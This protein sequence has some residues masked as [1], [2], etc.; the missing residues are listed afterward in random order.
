MSFIDILPDAEETQ[1]VDSVV[2]VTTGEF[3]LERLQERHGASLTP[4]QWTL[5]AE[6]GWFGLTLDEAQGGL[7]LGV[8][9][10]ALLHREFGRNLLSP[11]LVATSAMALLIAQSGG[12][13]NGYLTG[14]RRAAFALAQGQ[15]FCLVDAEGV[16]TVLV[17]SDNGL[18]MLDMQDVRSGSGL[19]GIDSTLPL[20]RGE[21]EVMA[22]P[23]PEAVS[24]H[25]E[26][27]LAA[28]LSG[29]ADAA[30]QM[31]TEYAKIRHQFGKPIGSFQAIGHACA[32]ASMRSEAAHAQVLFA[33]IALR[34]DHADA[35][36]Q[37]ASAARV[38]AQAAF[39]N[40]T[41][42]IHTHGGMGYSAECQA[43]FYL[44]RSLL[45]QRLVNPLAN[46]KGTLLGEG[47]VLQ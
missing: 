30:A 7:G 44:K 34:D 24:L 19:E 21:C 43:H 46:D 31:A 28:A 12:Q 6:M 3:P 9:I 17:P 13:E 8:T 11:N 38:A 39:V 42:N 20:V 26:L 33:A 15:G 23:V 22:K 14:E 1:I 32:D 36:F 37:V 25:V 41:M 5:A 27:L 35:R 16:D 40:A 10:E 29:M 4:A 2:D 18:L 45:L 47:A